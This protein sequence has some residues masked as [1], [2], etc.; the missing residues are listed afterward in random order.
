MGEDNL[1]F[2]SC[3]IFVDEMLKNYGLII[4][5]YDR[6]SFVGIF[7]VREFVRVVEIL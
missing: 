4:F 6:D 7:I 3:V 1:L 2:V 5:Y